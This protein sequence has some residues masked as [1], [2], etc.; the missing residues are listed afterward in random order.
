L[1]DG[2]LRSLNIRQEH[3]VKLGK[4]LA[5]DKQLFLIGITKN[6]PIKMELNYTF[7][8]IDNYLQDK[9]KHTYPF[10]TPNNHQRKLCCWF[11]VSN[12]VLLSSYGDGSMF[13]KQALRGG[14]GIG[15]F[16]VA[17]L[18]YVEKLQNYDWVV[19]DLN[20]FNVIPLIEY[21]QL[22]RS[23][24]DLLTQVFE[25]LTRL[26][27]EH[28]ILGYPYPLLEAHNFVT[29]KNDFKELIINRVKQSMYESQGM[30]HVD[31]E[32]LFVDI[33]TRF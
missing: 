25:H 2:S 15:V 30:D 17:R 6:S 16:H 5:Q 32:N 26:T 13:A 1:R 12:P 31:I 10:R 29:L 22:Q 4:F 19:A 27:Q 8:H 21:E 14:R 28:Y 9:L 24:T 23:S 33:H 11:Q 3:L 18:D 7:R 20:I